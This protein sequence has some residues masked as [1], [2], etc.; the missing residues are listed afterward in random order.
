MG[1]GIKKYGFKALFVF[2]G[3][4][5]MVFIVSSGISHRENANILA[6]CSVSSCPPIGLD[7]KP[8][9]PPKC[10]CLTPKLPKG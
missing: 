10:P 9:R 5:G 6:T 2:L 1:I 7:D 3:I 8:P 4:V